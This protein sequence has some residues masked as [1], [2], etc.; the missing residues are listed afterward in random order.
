MENVCPQLRHSGW[1]IYPNVGLES[2]LVLS[3]AAR[4]G[5][6]LQVSSKLHQ[7][8]GLLLVL[9]GGCPRQGIHGKQAGAGGAPGAVQSL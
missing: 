8:T 2:S 5:E 3:W 1:I 9:L 6:L 4:S 7:L